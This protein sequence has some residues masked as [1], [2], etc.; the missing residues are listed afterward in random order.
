MITRT[1][2]LSLIGI[3]YYYSVTTMLLGE[4]VSRPR[5]V[6]FTSDKVSAL[7]VVLGWL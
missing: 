1:Y 7:L 2:R 5:T 4:D 3:A 6:K